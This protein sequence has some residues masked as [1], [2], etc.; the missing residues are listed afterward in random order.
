MITDLRQSAHG[1]SRDGALGSLPSP[2]LAHSIISKLDMRKRSTKRSRA[3]RRAANTEP[4]RACRAR[5]RNGQ[6]VCD[7]IVYDGYTLDMLIATGW[8]REQDADKPRRVAEAISRM[9]ADAS[10]R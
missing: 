1:A 7:G 8:L 3:A 6:A 2:S 10:R 9:L 4:Q 5:P